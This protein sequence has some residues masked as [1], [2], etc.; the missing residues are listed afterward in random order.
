M[1]AQLVPVAKNDHRP[2]QNGVKLVGTSV[3][4]SP[5]TKTVVAL[6]DTGS[7]LCVLPQRVADQF[8]GR[9]VAVRGTQARGIGGAVLVRRAGV[10]FQFGAVDVAGQEKPIQDDYDYLVG[11]F[12]RDDMCIIG[13]HALVKERV[14]V[15]WDPKA[16]TGKLIVP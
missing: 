9:P 14:E 11:P 6:I 4:G 1:P 7:D 10:K 12:P 2:C 8:R 15:V 5:L 16:R 13:M 3:A